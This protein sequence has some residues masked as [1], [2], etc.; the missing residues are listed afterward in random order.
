MRNSLYDA[1]EVN[2]SSTIDGIKTALRVIVRRFWAV[3]RDASGDTEE[4]VRFVALAA[5]ILV[6]PVRRKGYDAVLN[7]GVAADFSRLP[8]GRRDVG[9]G[10]VEE[11]GTRALIH[12]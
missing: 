4:A 3:P 9:G 1:L 12:A 6:D 5:S 8:I 10:A 11:G 7:S 2:S